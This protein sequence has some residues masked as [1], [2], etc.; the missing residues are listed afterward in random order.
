MPFE[1]GRT[2]TG[3]RKPGSSN[4]NSTDLKSRIAALMDDKFEAVAA[5]LEQLEAKDRVTAYLKFLEYIMP[6][7][8]E[9][10]IDLS[11]LSDQELDELLNKVLTKLD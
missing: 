9:Q 7:Q 4:R 10:K 8:R 11:A 6:K 5:D 1:R 2:K 3:G